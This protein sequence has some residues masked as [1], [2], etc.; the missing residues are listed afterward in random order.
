MIRFYNGKV[1]TLKNNMEITNDEVWVDGN[2]IV[3]IGKGC[4]KKADR[5]IDLSGNLL[6]P[7]F[8]N[9][10][11]HSAMTFA[12]SLAD[13]LPLQPWLFD[14]IFPMEAKLTSDDIYTLSRLAFLEYLSSGVTACFDMYYFPEAMVKASVDAG[15]RTVMTCGL[16]NFKESLETLEEYYNKFNNYNELIS[17]KLGFHAEYTTSKELMAGIADL[18]EK[19]KAPVFMHASETENEVKECIERYGKTPTALFDELGLWNYGGGAYHSVWVDDND[20]EIYKKRDVYAVINAGSNS[21]LASGIAPVTKMMKKGIPLAIG[22]DGPSSNNALDMFREMFLIAATQKLNDN[23]ASS[24]DAN[25]ILKMATV[26]SAKCMGLDNCDIIE[27]GKIADL[28]VIDLKRPNMQPI[29]NVTKNIVYSGSKENI[30][31]TM[32]N[33]KILYEN[34]VFVDT[35]IEKIYAEAQRVTDRIKNS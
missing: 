31:L 12:R 30:K 4:N 34:G 14:I 8:K 25:E 27:E 26:G 20:I 19:Y 3:F 18:A 11:T 5:E 32:V 7:S 1:L 17:Y 24:C 33:G 35:D 6:M 28:I 16:N 23:D 2:K 22:T 15:F 9:A 13:D 21:K 10:H 29:N